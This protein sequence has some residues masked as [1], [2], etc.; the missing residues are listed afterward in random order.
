V[1]ESIL[2]PAGRRLYAGVQLAPAVQKEAE[3]LTIYVRTPQ[4]IS[5][6]D[7]YRALISEEVRW[8][9]REIPYYWNCAR[10][11]IAP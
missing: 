8:L 3:H 1:R 9:Y 2:L 11:S 4:W 5:A 6:M 7:G 10:P